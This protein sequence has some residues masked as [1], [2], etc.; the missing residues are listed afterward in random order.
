MDVDEGNIQIMDV[1]KIMETCPT[2]PTVQHNKY[3][4]AIMVYLVEI[5]KTCIVRQD[6]RPI[7]DRQKRFT[8]VVEFSFRALFP[9]ECTAVRT[10]IPGSLY[11]SSEH[12]RRPLHVA[13]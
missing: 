13:R 7:T 3:L 9:P 2:I 6:V 11:R 8:A 12:M 1:E 10:A 4:V 5:K